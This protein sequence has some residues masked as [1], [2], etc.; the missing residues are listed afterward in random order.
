MTIEHSIHKLWIKSML[1]N[2]QN[3]GEGPKVHQYCKHEGLLML[4]MKL[5]DD[6]ES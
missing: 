2:R 4:H 1:K 6:F 3:F 5:K